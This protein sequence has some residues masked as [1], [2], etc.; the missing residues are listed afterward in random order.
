MDKAV[1]NNSKYFKIPFGHTEQYNSSFFVRTVTDWNQLPD[2]AVTVETLDHFK[3][4]IEP[5]D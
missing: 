3:Q 4:A 2:S 1:V 5:S